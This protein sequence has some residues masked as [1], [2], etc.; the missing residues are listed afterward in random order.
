M[1]SVLECAQLDSTCRLAEKG[2]KP[3][4]FVEVNFLH[5]L[6]AGRMPSR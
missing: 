5:R 1:V 2:N 3:T 4:G 6:V